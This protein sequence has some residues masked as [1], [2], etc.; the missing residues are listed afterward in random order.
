RTEVMAMRPAPVQ[1]LYLGFPCTMGADFID[2]ALIDRTICADGQQQEWH[3]QV[4]RLPHSLYPY[5]NETANG[6]ATLVRADFGLP[7]QAFVFCCLNNSYKIEPQI[8]ER[9]MRILK[10][11]PNSVLWLLGKGLDV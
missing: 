7:E 6:P 4:I 1:V 8:F 2:Y 9:W 5:D 3:E 10:A 11:V